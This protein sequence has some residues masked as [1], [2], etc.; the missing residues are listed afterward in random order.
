[1]PWEA[2]GQCDRRLVDDPHDVQPSNQPRVLRRLTL[3]VVEV[4]GVRDDRVHDLL[5]HE[6]LRS[7]THLRQNHRRNL[8]RREPLRLTLELNLDRDLSP[9][10]R[11]TSNDQCFMSSWTIESENAAQSAARCKHNTLNIRRDLVLRRV[12]DHPLV[13]RERDVRRRR[14]VLQRP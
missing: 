12:P 5:P 13:R 3:R 9:S 8:L 4:R 10:P 7:L 11:T 1:M 14:P 2:R 6:R